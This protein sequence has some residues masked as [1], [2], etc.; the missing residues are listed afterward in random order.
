MCLDVVERK[1][2]PESGWG[3]K[4]FNSITE[5]YAYTYFRET[6]L[7]RGVWCHS[8]TYKL[9]TETYPA[10]SYPS[11]FHIWLEKCE[12]GGIVRKVRFRKAHTLGRQ[13]SRDVIVA[14]DIYIPGPVK[15]SKKA[16]GTKST[17][18]SKTKKK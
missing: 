15:T 9:M 8:S 14:R 13:Y 11:G 6:K 4:Q 12:L 3:W 16:T 5:T 18:T 7:K 1:N 2:P 17:K 10:V